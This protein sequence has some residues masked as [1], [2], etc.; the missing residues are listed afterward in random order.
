MSQTSF[1]YKVK[2]ELC[3]FTDRHACLQCTTAEWTDLQRLPL[4]KSCCKKKFMRELFIAFGT[5]SDP[6]KTYH[7]EFLLPQTFSKV[8]PLVAMLQGFGVPPRQ[9]QRKNQCQLYIKEADHIVKLLNLLGAHRALLAFENLRVLRGINNQVN[10]S[11]NCETA[12]LSKTVSAAL[13]QIEAI[14]HI[15]A[16]A[17]LQSLP[18]HLEEVARLR[19]AYPD[20]TLQEIGQMLSP[21]VG[22]SGVN[23][24]L[25]KISQLGRCH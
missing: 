2:A 21:P 25:R 19:L 8:Q 17:G 16:S 14:R 9:K 10:R 13:G 12:N 6:A 22:K 3:A 5:A 1:S 7:V 18:P 4:K 15:A 11:V 23:H 24:R 20:A